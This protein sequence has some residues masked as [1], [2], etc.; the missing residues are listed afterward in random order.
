MTKL[1]LLKKYIALQAEDVHLWFDTENE[2][3]AYL[4]HELRKVAY[5][6]EQATENEIKGFIKDKKFIAEI[7]HD[8]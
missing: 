3:E 8:A 5:M 2:S 7:E 1:D 6:I 4:Q